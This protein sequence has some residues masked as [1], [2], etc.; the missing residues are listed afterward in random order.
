MVVLEVVRERIRE[1]CLLSQT[2]PS[3][4]LLSLPE[5]VFFSPLTAE[6]AKQWKDIGAVVK[7]PSVASYAVSNRLPKA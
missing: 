1:L 6:D 5:H 2:T 4:E 7:V 3:L